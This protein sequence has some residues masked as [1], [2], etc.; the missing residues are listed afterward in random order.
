[1]SRIIRNVLIGSAVAMAASAET[2]LNN[3]DISTAEAVPTTC[4]AAQMT[5]IYND[6]VAVCETTLTNTMVDCSD[7]STRY[8]LVK[9]AAEADKCGSTAGSSIVKAAQVQRLTDVCKTAKQVPLADV[10]LLFASASDIADSNIAQK[11]VKDLADAFNRNPVVK[12][13]SN[14]TENARG[15]LNARGKKDMYNGAVPSVVG[16]H[17]NNTAYGVEKRHS[18]THYEVPSSAMPGSAMPVIE[19]SESRHGRR[20]ETDSSSGSPRRGHGR[21]SPKGSDGV[22]E[23]T[24]SKSEGKG[25]EH[26]GA[27]HKGSGKSDYK[28]V[29]S[30]NGKP[31]YKG[32]GSSV[33]PSAVNGTYKNQTNFKSTAKPNSVAKIAPAVSVVIAVALS[34]FFAL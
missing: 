25:V 6:C 2:A 7:V 31:E 32:L 21:G 11:Q 4:S 10:K 13:N 24:W 1:M 23:Y 5:K 9:C 14:G 34:A 20:E 27:E 12:G 16:D 15:V 29:S 26:K 18:R 19:E 8:M 33:A 28:G 22:R 17:S 30:G 3:I